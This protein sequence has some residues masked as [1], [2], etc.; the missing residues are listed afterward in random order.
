VTRLLGRDPGWWRHRL[1]QVGIVLKGLDGV[2]EVAGGVLLVVLGPAGVSR[3]IAFLTQ[4]ELSEDPR[5]AV[6]GWVVDHFG[7][8]GAGTVHFA[9]VYLLVHGVVKV[10]LVA[11]LIRERLGIFP[12]ALG[13]LGTFILYQGYRLLI[14]PSAGLAFLTALDLVIM[15]L[16]WREY[17]AVRRVA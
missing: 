3:V 4:H 15:A 7:H 10:V 5:D 11:G 6:A 12:W 2:L 14:L 13:F 8:I 9:A 1:F 16:V 17:E